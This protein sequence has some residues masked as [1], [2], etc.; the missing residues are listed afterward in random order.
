MALKSDRHE[1]EDRACAVCSTPFRAQRWM[2][3]RTCCPECA[4]TWRRRRVREYVATYR[5]RMGT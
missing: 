1:W 4:K 5:A 3:R 2:S